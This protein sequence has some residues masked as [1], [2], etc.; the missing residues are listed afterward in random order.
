[1]AG[2]SVSIVRRRQ[3]ALPV[4]SSCSA[5]AAADRDSNCLPRSCPN[6][7][8]AIAG[9]CPRNVP[10][11]P[12]IYSPLVGSAAGRCH[13]ACP[14]NWRG[15]AT[16]KLLLHDDDPSAVAQRDRSPFSGTFPA[17]R[18]DQP[19]AHFGVVSECERS[20]V[21]D[22]K[23][24]RGEPV[25]VL[26]QTIERHDERILRAVTEHH[27]DLL[28]GG[29]VPQQRTRRERESFEIGRSLCRATATEDRGR[30]VRFCEIA[31]GVF[32]RGELRA[33]GENLG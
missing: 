1:M 15:G 23:K 18:P 21:V 30:V 33:T 13:S 29:R 7:S 32:D 26:G 22:E 14:S 27:H 19:F 11:R 6:T 8:S 31:D 2:G 9:R 3:L 28:A 4:P 25:T 17:R 5:I 24:T 16:A 10:A 20:Q 12:A